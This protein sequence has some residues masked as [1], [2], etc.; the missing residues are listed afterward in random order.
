[1]VVFVTPNFSIYQWKAKGLYQK[2]GPVSPF[3]FLFVSEVLGAIIDF[4]YE[5]GVF[6]GFVV[7]KDKVHV[8]ILKVVDNNLIFCKYDDGM[9]DMIIKAIEL[10]EWC[11][12]QKG[13]SALCGVSV[14]EEKLISTSSQLYCKVELLPFLNPYT[15]DFHWVESQKCLVLAAHNRKIQID[16]NDSISYMEKGLPYAKLVGRTFQFIMFLFL[17]LAKVQSS[18]EF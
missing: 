7:G 3:L 4:I 1:M 11:S 17:M 6:E 16:G 5:R 12:S 8:S 9:L 2:R 13:K 10:F 18:R 15:L 14:D